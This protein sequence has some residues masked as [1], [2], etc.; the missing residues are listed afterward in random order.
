MKV[1]FT[2]PS[3]RATVNAPASLAGESAPCPK[4]DADI[5]RWPAPTS[6]PG[7]VSVV[8][9][10]EPAGWYYLVNG[11]RRGPVTTSQLRS[12]IESGVVRATD[13]LWREGMPTWT[14]AGTVPGLFPATLQSLPPTP[15]PAPNPHRDDDERPV[16]SKAR[17]IH[18]HVNQVI[19]RDR[20]RPRRRRPRCPYCGSSARPYFRQQVSGAGWAVFVILLLFTI[21]LCFI[22]LLI[23][24]EVAYCP[25][26]GARC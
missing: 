4:C 24:E 18:V 22:G 10:P 20:G 5:D 12:L 6:S 26:C 3:C 7:T 1:A 9:P 14:E 2:C 13:L 21:V 11:A 17:A 25:D 16:R 23:T 15:P 19:E 8:P